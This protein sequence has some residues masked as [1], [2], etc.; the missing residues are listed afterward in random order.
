MST[1]NQLSACVTDQTKFVGKTF[2]DIAPCYFGI[3]PA[4]AYPPKHPDLEKYQ[5]GT[6]T[7]SNPSSFISP[8]TFPSFNVVN[9][10]T[11]K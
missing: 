2:V 6:A 10:P 1:F 7:V 3:E 9:D 11:K 5:G 4:S 8:N